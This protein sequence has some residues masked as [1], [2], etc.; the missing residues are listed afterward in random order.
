MKKS[1]II[2]FLLDILIIIKIIVFVT[3]IILSLGF[4]LIF[5]DSFV[6][7]D[8]QFDDWTLMEEWKRKETK[9]A[10]KILKKE[11]RNDR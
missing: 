9:K 1:K 5:I 10:L 6:K 3:F 4:G 11:K 7:R 2:D 8:N